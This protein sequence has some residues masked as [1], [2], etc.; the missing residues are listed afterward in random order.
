MKK[1]DFLKIVDLYN[2]IYSF[3]DRLS[4]IGIEIKNCKYSNSIEY[5]IYFII[6][7]EYGENGLDWF[8]WWLYE[9]PI[10][11]NKNSKEYYATEAD[12]TPI[13]LDTPEQLYDFLE[14]NKMENEQ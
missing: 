3:H 5:I 4:D 10:L 12:G 7:T 13:I 14:K 9:L 1:E 6:K 8:T 11:K 2:N